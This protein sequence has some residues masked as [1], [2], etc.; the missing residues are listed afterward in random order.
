VRATPFLISV[1]GVTLISAGAVVAH[2]AD[3]VYYNPTNK[4]SPT[5][6]TTDYEDFRTIGCP[7][8][9]LL[10]AP[11]KVPDSDRDGVSD[12][13]DKC[14]NTPAGRKVNAEGCELDGDGDGVVD[15]LD[16]CP[17][18][19]AGRKVNAQG[20]ELDGD[21]DGVVDGLDKCPNTPAGRKVN[22][23]G[24]ELDTDGDG[25]VDAMDKC[26][27]VPAKTADGCPAPVVEP[28][29]APV[30][31]PQ[32]LVLGDVLFDTNEATL[33]QNAT[34][35]LDKA[36]ASLQEW[37]NVKVEVAGYTDDRGTPEY[38]EK[39]SVRRADAVRTYLIGKGVAA[40]RLTTKGYGES[41]PVADNATV[42]GR[43][44]NRRVELVPMK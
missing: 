34:A 16:K 14:P 29:P 41:N 13:L 10:D 24:C 44:E 5:G 4:A 6:F 31:A 26:P 11:C 2:A 9:Q 15:G 8:K 3:D 7:G 25:V 27:T 30:A 35:T 18:T 28:A 38:N 12:N 32:K 43:T 21:G 17:N 19:P 40:D 20:C 22:A 39:L 37:G 23:Q 36:A 33:T 42:E 1:L